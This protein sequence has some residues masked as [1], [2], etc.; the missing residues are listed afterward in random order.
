MAWLAYT[1]PVCNCRL[2]YIESIMYRS[3]IRT[4]LC[5]LTSCMHMDGMICPC[6]SRY[7][8]FTH[9]SHNKTA[10]GTSLPISS[11]QPTNQPTNRQCLNL[12]L[13]SKQSAMAN[14]IQQ[15]N[16]CVSCVCCM[17]G[18]RT[19][20]NNMACNLPLACQPWHV[21]PP[22]SKPSQHGSIV[23]QMRLLASKELHIIEA[24]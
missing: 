13:P 2:R 3:S 24:S 9:L 20:T 10:H 8:T 23:T 19:C 17:H 7:G 22:V 18:F 11:I 16:R 5:L 4:S 1:H 12:P 14:P 6:S 15:N 21:P